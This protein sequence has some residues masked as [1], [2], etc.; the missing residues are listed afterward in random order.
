MKPSRRLVIGPII[1]ISLAL[2]GA[3]A[4]KAPTFAAKAQCRTALAAGDIERACTDYVAYA[5]RAGEDDPGLLESLCEAVLTEAL[6][7]DRDLGAFLAASS[8]V[9]LVPKETLTSALADPETQTLVS[10]S[11]SRLLDQRR[12]L[13]A[14][15]G[16]DDRL[17]GS[18]AC[19]L[20]MLGD[21]A[22]LAWARRVEPAPRGTPG[23]TT[24]LIA[25]ILKTAGGTN[26]DLD[27]LAQLAP[28]IADEPG[29]WAVPDAIASIGRRQ[30]HLRPRARAMLRRLSKSP[31]L[32]EV[33][34]DA[35]LGLV[36]LGDLDGVS[37]RAIVEPVPPPRRPRLELELGLR[38]FRSGRPSGIEVIES[39][40]APGHPPHVRHRAA[41]YLAREVF[42]SRPEAAAATAHSL[43]LQDDFEGWPLLSDP[44]HARR[45]TLGVLGETGS[46]SDI[47]A[48]RRFLTRE[49]ARVP[50]AGAILEIL[51]GPRAP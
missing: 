1:V 29:A 28:L 21:P 2:A 6:T 51:R 20:A 41:C 33:H 4:S 9:S 43:L 19:V 42:P 31:E 46:R 22:G 18:S 34:V 39:H 38:L 8:Y 14:E 27:R 11:L 26:D 30:P 37:A 16:R 10:S 48:A 7:G 13:R 35:L 47:A 23:D 45:A 17:A 40:T 36:E 49:K 44:E 3:A 12:R 50:A 32:A 24:F 5:E 15:A 25:E